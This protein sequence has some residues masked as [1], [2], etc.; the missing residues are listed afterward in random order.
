[1]FAHVLHK[2]VQLNE[3]LFVHLIFAI[4]QDIP[5]PKQPVGSAHNLILIQFIVTFHATKQ[6][7]Y[8]ET[9]FR[10]RPQ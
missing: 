9:H 8:A 6:A 1:M 2:A 10:L 4:V 5:V 3:K 7:H